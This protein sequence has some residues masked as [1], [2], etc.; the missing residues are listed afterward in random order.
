MTAPA[1]ASP[2]RAGRP[3]EIAEIR[4]EDVDDSGRGVAYIDGKTTLIDG[5]LDGEYITYTRL[6]RRRR[7]NEATLVEVLE[8]SAYRVSPSC[9]HFAVCGACRFQHLARPEQRQRKEHAFADALSRYGVPAPAN[10]LA[11]LWGAA[12]G[13]RRKARLGVKHVPGKGGALVGFHEKRGS[14]VAEIEACEVLVPSVGT[15]IDALRALVSGLDAR[16]RIPQIEVA[17]GENAVALVIRHLDPL[18]ESDR[19]AIIDF[20]RRHDFCVYLQP[21]G[22][23]SLTALWP[24]SPPE[25]VYTIPA[26]NLELAFGPADF[27][28]TNAEVNRQLVAQVVDLLD[29]TDDDSV[30]DLYCGLGNFSLALGRRAGSVRGIEFSTEM[31]AAASRNAVR[32]GSD[33]VHFLS[34][35]LDEENDVGKSL[36]G[37]WNK[38][39]LDPPRSGAARVVAQLHPPY[40]SRIVYVSCNPQSFARDAAVLIESHPYRM[41]QAGIV[42][43]FPHTNHLEVIGLFVRS[44]E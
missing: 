41:E 37:R 30:L 9:P 40:P 26:F 21:K 3:S 36:E 11:P 15:R 43:M 12:R 31:V 25:L 24:E 23:D 27:V 44:A 28:Q 19:G 10:R 16:D 7:I 39:L 35:N 8:R 38:L 5:A 1:T 4:I 20:G 33:N 2:R 18:S 6:K 13:Y 14:F 29:P 17:A 22:P 42:D 34:A 32:N